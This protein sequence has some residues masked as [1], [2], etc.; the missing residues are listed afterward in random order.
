VQVEAKS[1]QGIEGWFRLCHVILTKNIPL[2]IDPRDL[3]DE[4]DSS[5]RWERPRYGVQAF[6]EACLKP[7][8]AFPL[9][10]ISELSSTIASLCT[11]PDSTLDRHESI[12]RESGD[13]IG[14]AINTTRGRALN[15]L[16]DLVIWLRKRGTPDQA[17]M[18]KTQFIIVLDERIAG[19]PALTEPEYAFL[20]VSYPRLRYIDKDWTKANHPKIFPREDLPLWLATVGSLLRYTNVDN[21]LYDS[22]EPEY[23]LALEQIESFRKNAENNHL[24]RDSAVSALGQ[25]LFI[26]YLCG[27][28]SLTGE[29]SLIDSYAQRITIEES[30]AF[31]RNIGAMLK[32]WRELPPDFIKRSQ[33]FLEWRIAAAEARPREETSKELAGFYVWL[34][35]EQFPAEW[36]LRMFIR[37]LQFKEASD[38]SALCVDCLLPLI[39]VHLALVME[40]FAKLTTRASNPT[41]YIQADDGRKILAA[42][43]SSSDAEIVQNAKISREHLVAAGRAEFLD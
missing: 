1:Y 31:L 25:H 24:S 14:T 9:C 5:P 40:C 8:S 4:S 7:D 21:G 29:D 10:H 12:F 16:Q 43:F 2:D 3:S 38:T 17:E 32:N 28:F 41:F 6:V 36:R 37:V 39:T 33:D 30:G 27:R 19:I 22:L 26:Y 13:P 23:R 11:G 15:R 35:N 18:A 34:S 20:A 42:G